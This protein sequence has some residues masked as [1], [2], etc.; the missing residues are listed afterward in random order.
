MGTLCAPPYENLLMRYLKK[1]LYERV[2]KIFD[3]QYKE[4]KVWRNIKY[5]KWKHFLGCFIFYQYTEF[6]NILNTLHLSVK[7]TTEFGCNELPYLDIHIKI[8]ESTSRQT[9]F[10]KEKKTDKHQYLNFYSCYSS[11]IK[12]NIPY[13]IARR[14]CAIVTELKLREI[15]LNELEGFPT[16][17]KYPLGLIN[18]GIKKPMKLNITQLRTPEENENTIPFGNTHTPGI[19]NIFHAIES[20]LDILLES[21][22]IKIKKWLKKHFME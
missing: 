12:R 15:R 2:E 13:S 4:Y 11:Q 14:I 7:F 6:I 22:K 20:N 21:S 5:K 19:T 16:M 10:R 18:K 17:Q 3:Q 9:Y 1:K 8:Q